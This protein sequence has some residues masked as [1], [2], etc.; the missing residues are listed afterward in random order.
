MLA[1]D[2]SYAF[3]TAYDEAFAAYSPGVLAEAL[4][5]REFHRLPG[6]QWMDSYTEP[7]NATVNRMW[8]DRLAMQSVALAAGAWGA[9]WLSVYSSIRGKARTGEPVRPAA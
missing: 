2:G 6:V 5:L 9:F 3:Q 1:A 7:D 8:K 4:S